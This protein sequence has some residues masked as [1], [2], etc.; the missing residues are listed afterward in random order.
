MSRRVKEVAVVGRD[1][2]LWIAATAIQRSFGQTGVRVRAFE[3]PSL[4]RPVDAYSA[5]PAVRGLHKQIGLNEDLA[6]AAANAVPLV[7]QRYSNWAGASPPWMVGYD[8]PPPP[9]SDVDFVHYWVKG[10][11]EGLKPALEDFSLAASAAKHAKVPLY[12]DRG[13]LSAA[14]GCNLSAEPYVQLLKASARRLGVE[15]EAA[16]IGDIDVRGDD[17]TAITLSTGDRIDSDLFVDASGIEGALIGRLATGGFESWSKWL[18]CDR[19]VVTSGAPINPPP[20]YSQISAFSAGWVGLYPLQDRTAVVAVYSS[21]EISDAEV[22]ERLPLLA[23]IQIGG[24]AIASV[25]RPGIRTR[26]WSGNC[27]AVGE[28]AITLD[29]LESL[30]L[31]VTHSCVSHLMALFPAQAGSYPEAAQ[32]NRALARVGQN[33]RDIQCA[34][35]ALNRRF[36]EPLWDRCRDSALPETLQRKL[37]VFSLTGHVPLYDDDPFEEQQWAAL[38][39]GAG[40][41]PKRYDPRIDV[42]PDEA[43]IQ[44][45]Q[46]RLRE[47]AAVVPNMPSAAEFLKN[48]RERLEAAR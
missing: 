46:Q 14:Y 1:A 24:E 32:Y 40:I 38:L 2:A 21:A 41:F 30:G 12:Q 20:V 8:D 28:A 9:G 29:P 4:L 25:L 6:F 47:I 19:M 44:K 33:L 5:M 11:Q 22:L 3:L 15:F 10:R 34:H 35:Y 13:E 42:A 45:V 7:A 31:H 43:L 26:C 37:E 16:A 39:G 27:V 17:I 36:D 48:G 18:P 23:G